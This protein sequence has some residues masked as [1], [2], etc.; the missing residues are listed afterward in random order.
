MSIYAKA[1]HPDA[2]KLFFNW[3][4]SKEGQT[5]LAEVSG[6]YSART[7]VPAPKDFPALSELN[8]IKLTMDDWPK[9]E[10]QTDPIRAMMDEARR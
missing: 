1:P 10:A 2:A 8:L 6:A 3:W 9:M 7:D 4:N 5:L